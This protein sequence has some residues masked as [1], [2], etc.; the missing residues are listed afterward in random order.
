MCKHLFLVLT[1]LPCLPSTNM[2]VQFL[3]NHH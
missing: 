3:Y 2:Y 1:C